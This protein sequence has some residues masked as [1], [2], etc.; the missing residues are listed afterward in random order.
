MGT[1][2]YDALGRATGWIAKLIFLWETP[3]AARIACDVNHDGTF[4]RQDLSHV[5]QAGYYL[6]GI[7]VAWEDGDWNSDGV[8]DQ[9]D[10]V[11]ALQSKQ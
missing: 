8:F 1:A 2:T 9:Y 10:I 3:A 5:V 4:D 6:R 7:Q 11:L